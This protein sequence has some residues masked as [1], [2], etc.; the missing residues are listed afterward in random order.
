MAHDPHSYPDPSTVRIT[1]LR[2]ATAAV[3]VDE[4]G[5]VLL[6]QRSDNGH[7]GLPGGAVEA[8]ESVGAAV[9]R[10]VMEETGCRVDVERVLGIYSDP[11][12][13]MIVRYPDGNVV[14]YVVITFVCRLM[15]GTP[16]PT[17]ESL[18][19]GWFGLDALPEPMVP[20]HRLRLVDFAAGGREVFIR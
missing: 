20:S 5:R 8:G 19:V 7:W 11:A 17:E 6:Q 4:R 10:E 12:Y 1:H 14:H 15:G 9:A 13:H 18:Q 3:I 16:G 2:V